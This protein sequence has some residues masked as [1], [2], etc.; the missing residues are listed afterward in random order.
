VFF[1]NLTL[2]HERGPLLE[3]THYYPFG[4]TMAG[5]SSKAASSLDNKFEYNGKEKQEKEFA[6]GSG[7][8]WYDYGA[9]MYDAQVG[10]WTRQDPLTDA[11]VNM[12]FSPYN[13]CLNNPTTLVDPDGMLQ[14]DPNMSKEQKRQL[15]QIVAGS[16]NA[17][18]GLSDDAMNNLLSVTGFA[19][20]KALLK[21]LKINGEGPVLRF[22]DI[23]ESADN[24]SNTL[25][26]S[27]GD[28]TFGAGSAYA[29]SDANN[30]VLDPGISSVL[31]DATASMKNG[32]SGVFAIG[33]DGYDV[34]LNAETALAWDFASRVFT[35]EVAHNAY[36]INSPSGNAGS[37]TADFDL[38]GG[39]C[40]PTGT[41]RGNAAE[42]IVYGQV[43]AHQSPSAG[44]GY[45]VYYSS[46]SY[47]AGPKGH[48]QQASAALDARRQAARQYLQQTSYP[49]KAFNSTTGTRQ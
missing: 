14:I 30:I 36:A 1:D 32:A 15:R 2:T 33:T 38:S 5:I 21:H 40:L 17:I 8:E 31:S 43:T 16:V 39:G 19:D 37:L 48:D 13:Y 41:E 12:P 47:S 28:G 23:R 10:R 29:F 45:R 11:A 34:N 9:R 42:R 46:L 44:I 49:F 7:L 27:Q 25:V 4:L 24:G 20:K 22:G 6:D 26:N 35:H 18:N 3:E